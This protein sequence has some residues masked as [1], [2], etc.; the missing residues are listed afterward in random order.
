MGSRR[1]K[2]DE[3]AAPSV[4]FEAALARTRTRY[5]EAAPADRYYVA[6][7]LAADPIFGLIA[8]LPGDFGSVLDLGCG[9]G[10]LGLLLLELG[11]ARKLVG[12][13]ADARKLGVAQRTGPEAEFRVGDIAHAELPASDTILLV[14]VLHY[15]SRAEQD[16]LLMAA[17]GS[18][19]H[20]G[21][22]LVRELDAGPGARSAVTR[23]FEWFARSTG[24]NR[25]RSTH[26]RPA[27][28]LT[29]LLEAAGLACSVLGASKRTPFANVL[30]VA[31]GSSTARVERSVPR[32]AL[33]VN[34]R[35][36]AGPRARVA[37]AAIAGLR[38]SSCIVA[39]V[40]TRGDADDAS[41][42]AAA[43]ERERAD[44]AVAAGGDGT[45]GSVVTALLRLP[46]GARAALGILPLGTGNNAARSFGLR[47]LRRERDRAAVELAVAAIASG[48]RRAIDVGVV[49]ERPFLGC[50]AVGLDGEILR[51]RNRMRRRLE[52]AGVHTGYGLYLASFALSI[53]SARRRFGARLVLDGIEERRSLY[54]AVVTNAPVYGG[55]LR[56]DGENECADGLLDLHAVPS[57]VRYVAEYPRAWLRYLRVRRGARAAPSPLLLRAREIVIEPDRPVAALIDGEEIDAA[58]SYRLRALP[59]A[60]R[61][62]TPAVTTPAGSAPRR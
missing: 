59:R 56:F 16:A 45:V 3:A 37:A 46:D 23:L 28:E 19:N 38:E 25:G 48:A 5:A 12:I 58:P 32:V 44:V 20:G 62:C 41:R 42:I 53:V 14:D 60:I 4:G 35:L 10:Q 50:F 21:R 54:N 7:K 51:L 36:R 33:V 39:E 34:P 15:L 8:G 47:S 40:E 1:R 55:P 27:R 31:G 24:L 57:A 52:A 43:L 26:Y 2:A 18:L 17:A 22:L 30:I 61:V 11:R 6:G 29:R 13:D 9:R 49:G